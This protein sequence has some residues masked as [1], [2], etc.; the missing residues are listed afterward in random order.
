MAES[1]L[2][3]SAFDPNKAAPGYSP[4]F[5]SIEFILKK[6]ANSI[7]MDDFVTDRQILPDAWSLETQH[8]SRAYFRLSELTGI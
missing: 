2:I 3:R 5:Y 6:W 8:F 1:A 4:D 7:Y